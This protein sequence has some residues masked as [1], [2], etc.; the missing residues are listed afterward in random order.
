MMPASAGRKQATKRVMD[1][2]AMV[3]KAAR[4]VTAAQAA[5]RT[6]RR[7]APVVG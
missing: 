1:A 5:G 6:S 2:N 3:P 7:K 4:V